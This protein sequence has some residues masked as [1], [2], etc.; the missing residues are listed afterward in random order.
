VEKLTSLFEGQSNLSS[1][2]RAVYVVGGLGLAAAAV[3][4]RPNPLLNLLALVGGSYLAFSGYKGRCPAKAALSGV[5]EG[6]IGRISSRFS[7][8][9][10]RL[11]GEELGRAPAHADERSASRPRPT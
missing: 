8:S 11:Q 3:Q 5:S 9:E 10:S 7:S 4:P 1:T 2:Q 6:E